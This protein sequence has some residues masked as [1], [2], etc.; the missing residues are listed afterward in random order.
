VLASQGYEL[1][2]GR[3]LS[4]DGGARAQ[5]MFQNAAGLRLTLYLGAGRRAGW[6][7]PVASA[8]NSSGAA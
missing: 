3:L 5:F 7:L 2:G 1:V 6:P 8:G 4:G